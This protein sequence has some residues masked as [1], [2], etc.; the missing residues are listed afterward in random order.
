[1]FGIDDEPQIESNNL[2][3]SKGIYA[4]TSAVLR[5]FMHKAPFKNT[6]L[7][8]Y[9][10]YSFKPSTVYAITPS[11]YTIPN[12][13]SISPWV[14]DIVEY[15]NDEAVEI[16]KVLK[17]YAGRN[18]TK[19]YFFTSTQFDFIRIA[20]RGTSDYSISIS[21]VT[22]D[23]I[24]FAIN[25]DASD[26]ANAETPIYYPAKSND[27]LI[28]EITSSFGTLY[29][30][31]SQAIL[32]GY[33]TSDRQSTQTK[34]LYN[35]DIIYNK[36]TI[37]VPD[38][39]NI[40][41]VYFKIVSLSAFKSSIKISKIF[42]E[43]QDAY[44][45]NSILP[46][47]ARL[48][49]VTALVSSPTSD[50]WGSF[51]GAILEN[52]SDGSIKVTCGTDNSYP[53]IRI[54]YPL[55]NSQKIRLKVKYKSDSSA[56]IRL[57]FSGTV[58]YVLPIS[59]DWN[60]FE[61][62]DVLVDSFD[63][64][65]FCCYTHDFSSTISFYLKDIN[66]TYCEIDS[67]QDNIS[68]LK[69][70]SSKYKFPCTIVD[71]YKLNPFKIVKNS[72]IKQNGTWNTSVNLFDVYEFVI[73]PNQS[74][75]FSGRMSGNY[76]SYFIN[77]FDKEQQFISHEYQATPNTEN[78]LTDII[79]TAPYNA[80]FLYVNVLKD[81]AT[82]YLLK[83][84][85]SLDVYQSAYPNYI[86]KKISILGDSISTAFDNNAV[87]FTVLAS[88]IENNRTLQA[89]PTIYD[90]DKVIGG[91]TITSSMIGVLTSFTPVYGDEGKTVGQP[92]NY[93]S[94]TQD[95]IWWNIM[96]KAIGADILQNVSWSG[97]S[98]SSHESS[99][100]RFKT[101]WA[102]HD[103][104]IAKLATRDIDG[105]TIAPDVVIIY[106]GTNDMTHSPY[107]K[108]TDFGASA[109]EIPSTDVVDDGYG[110]KEAYAMTIQKIRSTY[111]MA[112]I[113]CC[114][115][116][117]FKRIAYNHWPTRNGTNT[118]PE[119]NNAIREVANQMGCRII[120]FDKDGITF[121]NCYPTY[122][123]DSSTTPTHPN[124]NG[125]AKMA[126]KAIRDILK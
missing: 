66:I 103:A 122:I 55:S 114:T 36:F 94:L 30:A 74:Y 78:L 2:V 11:F 35:A 99:I 123:S 49:S 82:F 69:D 95:F 67:I 92:L 88:D 96:A 110:F 50:K 93:N 29:T 57:Y 107:D 120:E 6:D 4:Y 44:F 80:V 61:L 63:R 20:L 33:Y 3:N 73:S 43:E 5:T 39:Q 15:H 118:L 121:E 52:Q 111:P 115:L 77:W 38:I 91:V 113:I 31:G 42:T 25:H 79:I 71:N 117:V 48:D 7:N 46:V 83:G 75:K 47:N 86:G 98:I 68:L 16:R 124:A 26:D 34:V 51:Q 104:Q 32:V 108:L 87:Q 101:S 65:Q 102:W 53:G 41:A 85:P 27:V 24:S 54:N 62:N 76:S 45:E 59:T 105:N 84:L 119:Y 126:E 90:V 14:I 100:E 116:N 56:P 125:H 112:E 64:I 37:S 1:M 72:A 19:F 58:N 40:V 109:T 8:T 89:Y 13:D 70:A 17:Q 60:Y 9:D 28:C 81:D 22:Y 106:R 97:A 10:V 23:N 21:E 12:S 18:C